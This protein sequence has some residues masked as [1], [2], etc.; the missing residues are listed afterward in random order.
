M[1]FLYL[2]RKERQLV[3][4]VFDTTDQDES[5]D[6]TVDERYPGRDVVSF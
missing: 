4:T 1:L 2:E 3:T 6:T 5:L